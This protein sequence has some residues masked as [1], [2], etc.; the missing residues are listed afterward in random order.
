MRAWGHASGR[1]PC[2]RDDPHAYSLDAAGVSASLP[3]RLLGPH[4]AMRRDSRAVR[5]SG[6][7]SRCAR[8]TRRPA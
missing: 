8:R 3:R 1:W 2:V 7:A 6:I 5:D 4:L